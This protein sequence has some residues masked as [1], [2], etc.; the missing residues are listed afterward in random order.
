ML[1]PEHGYFF[2]SRWHWYELLGIVMPLLLMLLAA[3]RSRAGSAVSNL[4]IACIAVGA[5]ATL[6]AACFV[7]TD[8]SFFLARIQPMRSFQLIYAVGVLLLGGFLA[9]YLRGPRVAF[10]I[11]LLLLVSALM[12]F[13]QKQTYT[14]SAHIEW[15]Y[16]APTNPW[17]QAFVWARQ[18]TPPDAVFAADPDYAK[19]STE[20]AQGFRTTAQRA[21]LSDGLK[22]EGAV[23]MFP[24]LAP[25][26]K[27]E[28]DLELGLDHISDQERIRR[29]KPAGVTWLLLSATAVTN[30]DCPYRNS[31][32][33][34][35]RLP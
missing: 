11:F 9:R 29:L 20:D 35:C 31:A 2:L 24:A 5:T 8:G 6:S 25:E 18:H 30:F 19:A 14:T 23:T 10:G 28:S 17:Q 4:C 21:V 3:L 7:H 33:A 22:D 34:I 27:K 26:W 1:M 32:A 16:A 12:L 15:P 13:V